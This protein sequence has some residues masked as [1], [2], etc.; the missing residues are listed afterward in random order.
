MTQSRDAN[1]VNSLS[2]KIAGV[3]VVSS[4]GN[5]GAS[6]RIVIRGNTSITGENQPLFVVNGIPMDNSSRPWS[7]DPRGTQYGGVD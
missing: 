1:V 4:G 5:V 3:N 2:G 7:S 6:S